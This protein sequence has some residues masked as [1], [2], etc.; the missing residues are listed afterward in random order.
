MMFNMIRALLLVSVI[1]A[2]L[3]SSILASLA[4][5][6]E[7]E[8][9]SA[10][11]RLGCTACHM[12]GGIVPPWD[13]VVS[14]F[15]SASGKY[16]SL[17]EFVRAEISQRVKAKVGAEPKSWDEL[18]TVMAGYVGK[19]PDDPNVRVVESYLASLLQ[20]PG[21]AT[22]PTTLTTPTSP[23]QVTTPAPE[24]VRGGERLTWGVILAVVAIVIIVLGALI[25][26][27]LVMRR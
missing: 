13:G 8:A 18:F 4:Q 6:S 20:A 16:P 14:M 11:E 10:F 3:T 9:K 1:G 12:S 26:G 21:A 15:R 17:D 5:P 2:L 25:V 22:P 23:P 19:K 27:L 24:A 7:A